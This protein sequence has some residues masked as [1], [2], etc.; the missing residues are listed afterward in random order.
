MK[1]IKEIFKVFIPKGLRSID[2]LCCRNYYI[3]SILSASLKKRCSKDV[4][5]SCECAVKD[6]TVMSQKIALLLYVIWV[7]WV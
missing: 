1:G 3:K 4:T 6:N 7:L 2:V 5:L